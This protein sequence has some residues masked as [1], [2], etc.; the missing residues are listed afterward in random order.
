M[1]VVHEYQGNFLGIV[2]RS[3]QICLLSRL[4]KGLDTRSIRPLE[5][6][7]HVEQG[8]R[9]GTIDHLCVLL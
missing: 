2:L 3:C 5:G 4:R 9:Q 7:L 1:L 6:I 8:R